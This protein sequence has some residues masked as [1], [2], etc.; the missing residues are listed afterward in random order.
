MIAKHIIVKPLLI[1]KHNN[2]KFVKRKF[3][4]VCNVLI[5]QYVSYAV[6]VNYYYYKIITL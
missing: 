3:L 5:N 1:V 6:Q 4:I 2:V